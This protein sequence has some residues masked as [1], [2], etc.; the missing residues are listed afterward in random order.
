MLF[1]LRQCEPFSVVNQIICTA[2]QQNSR[3]RGK[4]LQTDSDEV[5]QILSPPALTLSLNTM[6]LTSLFPFL[7]LPCSLCLPP[8]CLS[9]P[10]PSG[11]DRVRWPHAIFS[12]GVAS[13]WDWDFKS[14]Q[15]CPGFNSAFSYCTFHMPSCSVD[16][17]HYS[18]KQWWV[19]QM[20]IISQ[21]ADYL[22]HQFTI[23]YGAWTLKI[24]KHEC[25]F[26][27]ALKSA[28]GHNL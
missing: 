26:T 18:C 24:P 5:M 11:P 6:T 3:W 9:T 1:P 15:K 14:W 21:H 20:I 7:Y 8:Q 17:S 13:F 25:K 10:V 16:H 19:Y 4:P 27:R 23:G 12:L 22:Q 28:P 2:H